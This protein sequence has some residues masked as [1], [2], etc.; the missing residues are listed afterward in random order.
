MEKA[1][2][3]IVGCGSIGSAI[4]WSLYMR[5]EN[6]DISVIT[7]YSIHYT[8]LYDVRLGSVVRIKPGMRIPLD[9]IVLSGSSTI[10]QAPVTGESMPVEKNPDDIVYAGTINP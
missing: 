7:S 3:A 5:H 6:L 10:D 2:V 9:G 8:K 1:K 4:A